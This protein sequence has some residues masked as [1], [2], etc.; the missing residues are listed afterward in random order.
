[1]AFF[2]KQNQTL[3]DKIHKQY[4][5]KHQKEQKNDIVIILCFFKKQPIMEQDG[6]SHLFNIKIN[7]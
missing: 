5:L 7:C 2:Q 3:L 1:M 4:T 6:N